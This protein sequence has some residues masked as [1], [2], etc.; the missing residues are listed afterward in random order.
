LD[1]DSMINALRRFISV[2]GYPEQIRSDRGSNFTKAD[3]ELKEAIEGWN[4][5]KINNFCRQK[6]IEWIFNPPSASHMG[7][8]WER[9]IRSVRQILKA[10][11]KEQLVSDEVLS[12]VMAEAVNILNSR[13][14]TH[15]SDS[16][17]DE[18]PLTPNHLLHLRP[19]PGLPPGIFDKDDLSCR[20]AWRQAQYLANLFWRRWTSEYL[21]TLLERKKWNTPRRNLEVGDLVLLA[22]ESF[23]RGKWPLG[24]IV[25]VMPSRDGLVR[26]VKV[27]TSC[28]VA[29]RAK[30][31][32][33]GEPVNRDGTTVLTRPVTKLCLLEMD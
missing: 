23:P 22:D 6:K 9:M 1:T 33:K 14:L 31:Q 29:T 2:R 24:R 32:R 12:T 25:E 13:P 19:C 5:H 26:T 11:L 3:K 30:R 21:P 27:K 7:G 15:N 28:T 4:E 8:V 17:L 16:P 20:R 18:Q 10:I